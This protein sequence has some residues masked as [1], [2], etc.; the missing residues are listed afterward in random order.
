[1]AKK[2]IYGNKIKDKENVDGVEQTRKEFKQ[3][4][5]NQQATVQESSATNEIAD[6]PF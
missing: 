3:Q 2:I 1:M 5:E 6:L 4:Q